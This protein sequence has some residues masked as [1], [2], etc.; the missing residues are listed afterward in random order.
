VKK[1]SMREPVPEHFASP[2]DLRQF[3]L[4]T[5]A[6]LRV[7]GMTEAGDSLESAAKYVTSSGWEWLG[8]LWLAAKAIAKRHDLPQPL[9]AR[10]LRIVE[11][12]GSR[13]PYK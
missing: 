11:V 3:A 9:R 5:A 12:A 6:Q 10:V 4:D 1:T 13:H 2:S 8:E 7:V